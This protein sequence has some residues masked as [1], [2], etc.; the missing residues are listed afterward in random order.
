MGGVA[1]RYGYFYGPGTSI[2][3]EGSIAEDLARRRLPVIGSG[4]GVWS[5]IHIDDAASATVAALSADA[6][7]AFNICDDDPAPAAQWLPALADALGAPRPMRV[8]AFIARPLAGQH[9][10]AIMTRNQGASNERAKRELGW[11]PRYA[12]WRE[13]FRSGLA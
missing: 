8:P 11:S 5:F 12:S 10:V 6:S 1:L 2:S 7:G 9:G 3:P 13:G 4:A